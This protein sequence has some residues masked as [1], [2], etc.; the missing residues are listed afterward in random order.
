[1]D[2][3][4]WSTLIGAGAMIGQLQGQVR[5]LQVSNQELNSAGLLSSMELRN[6][7][8]RVAALERENRL[9]QQRLNLASLA[10]GFAAGTVEAEMP[11]P[12]ASEDLDY[13]EDLFGSIQDP[14]EPEL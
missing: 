1:M 10:S 14:F 12:D 11:W 13:L 3:K 5:Q 7:R 4:L 2:R 6:H 9:L 8:E